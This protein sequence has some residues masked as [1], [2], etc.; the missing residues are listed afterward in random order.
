[1][2]WYLYL[3]FFNF[4]AKNFYSTRFRSRDGID[5]ENRRRP[6]GKLHK[7]V[8]YHEYFARY[9]NPKFNLKFPESG[10]VSPSNEFI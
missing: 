2:N 9:N 5:R 4:Y 8:I 3:L 1:M 6:G 7:I 10:E